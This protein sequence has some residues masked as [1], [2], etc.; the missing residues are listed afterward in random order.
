MKMKLWLK[1]TYVLQQKQLFKLYTEKSK[2]NKS[3]SGFD[4]KGK[5]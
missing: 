1:V 2:M 5:Q 4:Y 3:A